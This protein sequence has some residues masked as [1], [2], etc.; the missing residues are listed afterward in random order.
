[1]ILIELE[2]LFKFAPN[3]LKF[4]MFM[5]KIRHAMQRL[6]NIRSLLLYFYLH[7]AESK[8]ALLKIRT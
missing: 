1:M 2:N 6:L 5:L 7:S 4:R 3:K 8:L